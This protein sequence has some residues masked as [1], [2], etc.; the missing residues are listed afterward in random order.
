MAPMFGDLVAPVLRGF[1]R[2]DDC[3][4]RDGTLK[5]K[6]RSRRPQPRTGAASF[7]SGVRA[8]S[9]LLVGMEDMVFRLHGHMARV[10]AV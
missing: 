3:A 1:P 7:L 2:Y 8:G 6:K 9:T 4:F 5:Q 10:S